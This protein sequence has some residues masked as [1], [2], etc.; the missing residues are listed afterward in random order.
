M[1]PL[2][3]LRHILTDK[4]SFCLRSDENALLIHKKILEGRLQCLSDLGMLQC[5]RAL[6]KSFTLAFPKDWLF[7][8]EHSEISIFARF[9][10]IC[11]HIT[12]VFRGLV[13]HSGALLS[14]NISRLFCGHQKLVNPGFWWTIL[15]WLTDF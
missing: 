6:S 7:C 1:S 15:L 13:Q 5:S 8:F 3:S 11:S 12:C 9:V 4:Q 10:S 2:Y 14:T